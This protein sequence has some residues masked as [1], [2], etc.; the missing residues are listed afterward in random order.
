MALNDANQILSL[1]NLSNAPAIYQSIKLIS[2]SFRRPVA[3]SFGNCVW[4]TLKR[5][6]G[7]IKT[8]VLIVRVARVSTRTPLAARPAQGQYKILNML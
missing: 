1:L 3:I 2:G 8:L 5:E 4:P 7:I 6:K